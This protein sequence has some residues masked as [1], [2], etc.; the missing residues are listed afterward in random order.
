[1][2]DAGIPGLADFLA[3]TALY[4]T[5]GRHDLDRFLSERPDL[6]YAAI[7]DIVRDGRYHPALEW[8]KAMSEGPVRPSDEPGYFEKMAAREAFQ[9]AVVNAMA[10]ASVD[11]LVYPSVQVAAPTRPEL[12]AGRWT[13]E[14]F[15]TNTLIAPQAGLPAATVPAGATPAGLPVGLEIMGLPYGEPAVLAVAYAFEQAARARIVPQTTPEL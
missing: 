9:R 12:E 13:V 15:P 7:A 3:S 10:R 2:V 5:H 1:V 11:V 4:L 8:L 14:A 6:P